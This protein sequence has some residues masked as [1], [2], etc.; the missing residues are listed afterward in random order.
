MAREKRHYEKWPKWSCARPEKEF[1]RA[2]SDHRFY[3]SKL[4]EAIS[5]TD[6]AN[7]FIKR[8]IVGYLRDPCVIA[9]V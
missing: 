9:I 1:S 7:N 6:I 4:V 3:Q 8:E 5:G 2:L